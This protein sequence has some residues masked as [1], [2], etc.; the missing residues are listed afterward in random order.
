M[1]TSR[2][3]TDR[4]E[5]MVSHMKYGSPAP[6]SRRKRN[7]MPPPIKYPPRRAAC[8]KMARCRARAVAKAPMYC[9]DA[10]KKYLPHNVDKYP[11]RCWNV[12][13]KCGKR[14]WREYGCGMYDTSK[15]GEWVEYE[16]ARRKISARK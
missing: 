14:R 16:Y 10:A 4:L 9:L 11:E 3:I 1:S 2:E 15:Y 13:D 5:R 8:D 7:K 12:T 6:P